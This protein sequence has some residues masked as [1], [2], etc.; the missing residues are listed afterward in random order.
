MD[1]TAEL[2]D[3]ENVITIVCQTCDHAIAGTGDGVTIV[4]L[5]TAVRHMQIT[6]HVVEAKI[7]RAGREETPAEALH[8]LVQGGRVQSD[9]R[10]VRGGNSSG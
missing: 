8:E 10:G 6:G 1:H 9:P 2:D 4:A 3:P 7:S 5:T